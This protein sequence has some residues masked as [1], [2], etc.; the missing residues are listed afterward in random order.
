MSD[1][2]SPDHGGGEWRP[3]RDYSWAPFEPGNEAALTH[4]ASSPRH[5]AP[6][7]ALI[8]Q[9]LVEVVPWVTSPAFAAELQAWAWAEAE[10]RLLRAW[11]DEHGI[12][13]DPDP[14]EALPRPALAA[15]H[16]AE[17]RAAKARTRLGLN[18]VAWARLLVDFSKAEG[19]AGATHQALQEEGR[20]ILEARARL[21]AQ[22]VELASGDDD[23]DEEDGADG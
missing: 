19:P 13:S 15:L 1:P 22:A 17:T 2:S 10:V 8:A 16:R 20:R 11:L 12:L 3:P 7:A 18:P 9:E 23:Q 21:E 4:G 6:L 14:A 5:V